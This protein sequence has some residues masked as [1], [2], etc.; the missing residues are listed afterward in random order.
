LAALLKPRGWLA[1]A[2]LDREDGTFH[3]HSEGVFHQGFERPRIADWLSKA[4]F[5]QV[6]LT[7]AHSMIKPN[8]TGQ[9]RN[10]PVFLAVGQKGRD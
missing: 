1:V 8:S 9:L 2:D 3:S 6:R 10:Y 7:D 5:T 4:G